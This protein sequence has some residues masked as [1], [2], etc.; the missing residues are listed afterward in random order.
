M[1]YR[2]VVVLGAHS[3]NPYSIEYKSVDNERAYRKAEAA[4]RTA[5]AHGMSAMVYSN[6]GVHLRSW[7][8]R[9]ARLVDY[10]L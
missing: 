4:Y 7:K 9:K 2:Y 3:S 6:R 10:S 8:P 1:S 5:V